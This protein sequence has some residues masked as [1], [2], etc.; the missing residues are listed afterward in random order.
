[1]ENSNFITTKDFFSLNTLQCLRN[2][3]F[4]NEC[5]LCFERCE[6]KALGLFKNKITLFT[7]LCIACGTCIGVCP[8]QALSLSHFDVNNF[9]FSFLEK[10]INI[11]VEKV[12]IPDFGML[13][14]L[15]LLSIA[16]RAK[17]NIFLE[18]HD[19]TPSSTLDYI[20]Q[21]I[22]KS[23]LFL[24][25]IGMEN[26]FFM[27]Q[28]QN[29]VDV[30]RRGLFKTIIHASHELQH[31]KSTAQ[32]LNEH[33]KM[34]PPKMILLKNSLKL[35]CEDIHSMINTQNIPIFN[36]KINSQQCTNCI[37]C[38]TFCPTHALFQNESK[39]S[40]LF[41]SGKCIGCNICHHV[42]KH[43]AIQEEYAVDLID[44][45]F[46]RVQ[47]LVEFEYIKCQECNNAF[48]DKKNGDICDICSD[49]ANNYSQMFTLAKDI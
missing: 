7:E 47:K 42:C 48:I 18:Y 17:R 11:I 14:S 43:N 15:Y 39:E 46:D 25:S 10:H 5:T 44:F 2:E 49:Y 13:D 4:F 12:D 33:Q 26:S 35:V 16:L 36:Q 32:K 3:Y 40:I 30:T 27:R 45:M 9:I 34:V 21:E 41:Q 37:E 28:H 31:D 22:K 23:N 29:S 8:T 24:Y 19:T 1:M 38:I 20:E 6:H